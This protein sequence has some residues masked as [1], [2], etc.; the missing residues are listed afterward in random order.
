MRVDYNTLK[1]EP[2][3]QFLA[4]NPP[5]KIAREKRDWGAGPV[6]PR[7]SLLPNFLDVRRKQ[8]LWLGLQKWL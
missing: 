2:Y 4:G 7:E 3:Q 1:K 8:M 6:G 5:A